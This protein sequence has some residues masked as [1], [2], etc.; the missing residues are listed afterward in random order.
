VGAN[1]NNSQDSSPIRLVSFN[2]LS[3]MRT[4]SALALELIGRK[5]LRAHDEGD[6]AYAPNIRCHHRRVFWAGPCSFVRSNVAE[7]L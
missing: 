3:V 1:A 2:A 5:V 7:K 4:T 6:T